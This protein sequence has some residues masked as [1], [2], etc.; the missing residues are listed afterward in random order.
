MNRGMNVRCIVFAVISKRRP[1]HCCAADWV[2]SSK[3]RMNSPFAV[4][5]AARRAR[6]RAVF[7]VVFA[8]SVFCSVFF[9]R[10]C[11]AELEKW[12]TPKA[13]YGHD[14]RIDL[15]DETNLKL[16][17]LAS[18]VC[19]IINARELR[20]NALT[21]RI[22]LETE[23][24]QIAGSML[25]EGERF[26]DQPTAPS[27]TAFLVA[28][29]LVATAGHCILSE[30]DLSNH[31]FVFG[32]VMT[33][34]QTA[35]TEFDTDRIYA[36]IELLT[37]ALGP[38]LDYAVVRLDRPVPPTVARPLVIRRDGVVSVGSP[39][40]L[41]GYP[42]GLPLKL[43]FGTDTRI[44]PGGTFNKFIANVDA[45]AGNSGSPVF[46]ASSL[47]VEGIL[48]TG[49]DDVGTR[50]DSDCWISLIYPSD[51]GEGEGATRI[52]ALPWQEI[53]ANRPPINDSWNNASVIA[54]K[55][56]LVSGTNI[57]ASR[58]AREPDHGFTPG[59]KS[60][61]WRW[62]APEGGVYNVSTSG[63][64][65]DTMLAVYSGE[66]LAALSRTQWAE[67]GSGYGSSFLTFMASPST[68]Y[69]F[70][71]EGR[72]GRAGR[73]RLSLVPGAENE[74]AFAN[75]KPISTPTFGPASLYPS[76]IQVTGLSGVVSHVRVR[77]IGLTH[78]GEQ[79]APN[80]L[81]VLLVNPQNRAT[82]LMSNA[83]GTN[84]ISNVD[85]TFDDLA[86]R[87]LP[88][89][90]E[91]S[92]FPGTFK[93]TVGDKGIEERFPDTEFSVPY[94]AALSAVTGFDPNGSW[95]LFIW[96]AFFG[97]G[98]EGSVAGWGL[99]LET[100][101]NTP[102]TLSFLAD[103]QLASPADAIPVEF[104]I[105]DAGTAPANLTVEGRSSNPML[106]PDD[107]IFIFGNAAKRQILVAPTGRAPGT[108]RITVTVV[109]GAGA[110]TSRD[111]SV[112][113][114]GNGTPV[115][116]SASP[117]FV[118]AIGKASLYPSGIQVSNVNGTIMDM[119]VLLAALTMPVGAPPDQWRVLL[120]G[121]QGQKVALM[122]F[123]G[124]SHRAESAVITFSD[125]ALS[126]LPATGGEPLI[127]GVY[128]PSASERVDSL[129]SP[130]PRSPYDINFGS[131]E[132]TDPNGTW[133]LF[134]EDWLTSL[135]ESAAYL[136]GWTLHIRTQVDQVPIILSAR[137]NP[138]DK[139][140]TLEWNS[141]PRTRYRIQSAEN[142]ASPSWQTVSD[143]LADGRTSRI[144]VPIS[145][146]TR[147]FRLTESV[148][149]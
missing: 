52:T 47:E 101:Q 135:P 43:A 127:T 56:D 92:P 84:R 41:M 71:V 123:S 82:L 7:G 55:S 94:G 18:S 12:L 138:S 51:N 35:V 4:E 69:Y 148:E 134:V 6:S 36:G 31:R 48:V 90:A 70:A 112:T 147:F 83:G 17:E 114:L 95:R 44:Q 111:F 145:T 15:R 11:G 29:D 67:N 27:C 66:S 133:K 75:L 21:G 87:F 68:S 109:D 140:I 80:Q 5:V 86:D 146:R 24:L 59:G 23:C 88:K 49:R 91:G 125:Q 28:P 104:E 89:D 10:V 137:A 113:V 129:A 72:Y 121:P 30:G 62:T 105:G 1:G 130:A 97:Y 42:L 39:V 116:A 131:F 93:P 99:V 32:F 58:E 102:P 37:H 132:N 25:C 117:M 110:T 64:D 16:R 61:W 14:D 98:S 74:H 136:G 3:T 65:F 142:L 54:G 50:L 118:P 85:L 40:G 106:V 13:V 22:H 2:N 124:G 120:V 107:R 57:R 144:E 139:R 79:P 19:G 81:R 119:A 100:V 34:G 46:N 149:R 38:E 8:I 53:T 26:R 9:D 45:F 63:S 141:L 60:V 78:S 77:V 76:E 126:G 122:N 73:I 128:R 143:L 96:D 115:F 108:A 33:D 20:T 103:Q